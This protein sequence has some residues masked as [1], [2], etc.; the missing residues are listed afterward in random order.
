MCS[1]VKKGEGASRYKKIVYG[2]GIQMAMQGYSNKWDRVSGPDGLLKAIQTTYAVGT[3][4]RLKLTIE[5]KR[6]MSSLQD[7]IMCGSQEERMRA[8]KTLLNI[9]KE[10]EHLCTVLRKSSDFRK[11]MEQAFSYG[12]KELNVV[13]KQVRRQVYK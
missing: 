9:T 3:I 8:A 12:D 4:D 10:D 11:A 1:R 6:T 5:G 13:L 2:S 7:K